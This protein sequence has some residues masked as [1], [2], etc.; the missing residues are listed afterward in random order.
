MFAYC[1]NNPVTGYD[2]MGN[3]DWGTF[4]NGAGL[5]STGVSAIV[6]ASAILAC[7]AAAPIMAA[8]ATVTVIAGAL[9]MVNGAAEVAEAATGYNVVRDGMFGGNT[10]A[11][12]AYR[13]AT[14]M[15][16][17]IGTAITG[18][19][20]AAKG[21]NVCFVEGTLVQTE[22]GAIPIEDITAGTRVWAWDEETGEVGLK[23]VV[24]TYENETYELVHVFVNGEEITSTPTHPFYSPVKGWT[25]AVHLRAGDVLVLVNGEYVVVEKVQHEILESPVKVYNFH[26]EDFHTYYV[27]EHGV[28]VHNRCSDFPAT[29]HGEIRIG[30]R[31][32]TQRE[33]ELLKSSTNI[34]TQADGATVYIRAINS[35]NHK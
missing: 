4:F 10:Q 18:S 3:W 34:R 7:G 8:V 22:Q 23:R 19:Y 5:I 17:E 21:G 27:A 6:A 2:P 31:G 11:Y 1:G 32:L 20:Y 28:L 35:N 16:A 30:E 14:A 13:D 9:T 26:V 33:Y 24:E 25:Q 29:N 15:V 12:E